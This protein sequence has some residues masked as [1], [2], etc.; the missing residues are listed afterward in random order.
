[1]TGL[2]D[3]IFYRNLLGDL[4]A[5]ILVFDTWYQLILFLFFSINT[6]SF[7]KK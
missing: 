7:V 3:F 5:K 2:V 6:Y 4:S 1:M